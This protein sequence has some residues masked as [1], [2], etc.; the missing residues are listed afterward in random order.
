MATR[1]I[2]APAA[3][4]RP[5]FHHRAQIGREGEQRSRY[6]LGGAIARHEHVVADPAGRHHRCLQQRQ[7]HMAAAE[8][9]GTR[10]IE[11]GDLGNRL[12][13]NGSAAPAPAAAIRTA[14]RRRGRGNRLRPGG[15]CRWRALSRP[16]CGRS[17]AAAGR[18][19]HRARWHRF[20]RR[21]PARTAPVRRRRPR[22]SRRV[23]P[24]AMLL[25]MPQTAC[26][27]TATAA[28]LSPCSQPG[29]IPTRTFRCRARTASARWRREA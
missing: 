3:A 21:C 20:G 12:L 16:V 9:Q 18:P 5:R 7:H 4:V 23:F 24:V 11:C 14:A 6:G 2:A 29:A 8:H 27:T 15:R 10:A 17:P 1:Q 22:A 28:I 26:A 13:Q 19:R 25:A